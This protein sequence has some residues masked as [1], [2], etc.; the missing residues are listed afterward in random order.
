VVYDAEHGQ[1]PVRESVYAG[2]RGTIAIDGQSLICGTTELWADA[3]YD[4]GLQAARLITTINREATE[5]RY[6]G[7]G[8]MEAMHKPDPDL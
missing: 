5:V 7:F 4:R 8:R 1:L 3:F 6:D 2:T